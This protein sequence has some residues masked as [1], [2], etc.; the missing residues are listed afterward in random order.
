MLD[1][2]AICCE[3]RTIRDNA[4]VQSWQGRMLDG[5][6]NPTIERMFHSEDGESIDD[7]FAWAQEMLN[8][9]AKKR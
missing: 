6:G 3:I 8:E 4:G 1:G 9:K 5:L 2:N 7:I